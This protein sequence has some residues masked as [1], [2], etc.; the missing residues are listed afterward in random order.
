MILKNTQLIRPITSA[1]SETPIIWKYI[2]SHVPYQPALEFQN[3]LVRHKIDHPNSPDWLILLQHKPVYTFGR[4]QADTFEIE[5]ER[6]RVKSIFPQADFISTL[7]GGQTT[8][9]GPGQLVGYPILNIGRMNLSTRMYVDLLLNFLQTILLHP[10]LP[11]PIET[12]DSRLNPKIPVGTFVG[13]EK[14]KIASIGV[15]IRRRI[16]SHGFALN[17]E[18]KCE[19]GFSHILACGLQGT[20]LIS[21]ESEL[22]PKAQVKVEDLV[23]P[24]AEVFGKLIRRNI[25]ELNQDCEELDSVGYGMVKQFASFY[26]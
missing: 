14:S 9:H 11:S 21:I 24:T 4:R 13:S 19:I 26:S 17:V 2:S 16:S 8:F 12:L 20:R 15:Q 5:A 3:A 22:G 7:R 1:S 23:K 25:K 18:R 10:C 6:N